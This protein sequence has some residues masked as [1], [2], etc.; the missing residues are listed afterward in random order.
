MESRNRYF[1]LGP[2]AE[3]LGRRYVDHYNSSCLATTT[4][5]CTNGCSLHPRRSG[6]R[7][8]SSA[9]PAA[10]HDPVPDNNGSGAD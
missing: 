4:S 8:R 10:M 3:E 6:K 1:A 9:K 2:N 7:P 5:G